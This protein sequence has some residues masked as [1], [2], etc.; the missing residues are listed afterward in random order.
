M[1]E[2]PGLLTAAAVRFVG[3]LV[4]SIE[5]GDAVRTDARDWFSPRSRD[6][7]GRPA[8]PGGTAL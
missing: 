2:S 7:E 8:T 4:Y 5:Q 3:P 1:A 6:G